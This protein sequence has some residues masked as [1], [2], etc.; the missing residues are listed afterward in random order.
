M[1]VCKLC[2]QCLNHQDIAQKDPVLSPRRRL[3]SIWQVSDPTKR[4]RRRWRR[5]RCFSSLFDRRPNTWQQMDWKLAFMKRLVP[6]SS[7][8]RRLYHSY[9]PVLKL[10]MCFFFTRRLEETWH[11]LTQ[12][13]SLQTLQLQEE[14]RTRWR[15]TLVPFVLGG[16]LKA[17]R[18]CYGSDEPTKTQFGRGTSCGNGRKCMIMFHLQCNL[19][20]C[21]WQLTLK[22]QASIPH[23]KTNETWYAP[24]DFCSLQCGHPAISSEAFHGCWC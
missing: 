13:A 5:W 15:S 21:W 16:L 3:Q 1:C 9:C 4:R 18:H 8:Q 20:V 7:A 2:M 19:L 10:L 12:A 17:W 14:P 23:R 22:W 24:I 11:S 6:H